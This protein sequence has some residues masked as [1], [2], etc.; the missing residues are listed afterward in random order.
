MALARG[1]PT[2][3]VM[4]KA[5][6]TINS[7]A[8][9]ISQSRAIAEAWA[10]S[11]V[12]WRGHSRA[13]PAWTLVPGVHRRNQGA[14][15]ERNI[16]GRFRLKAYTR[17][18]QCPPEGDLV[19]WLFLMQH[20]RLPT[21]LLDWSES[22]VVAA[23]FAVTENEAEDGALWALN[24]F[25]LNQ[26]QIGETGI[27]DAHAPAPEALLSLAFL[28]GKEEPTHTLAIYGREVDPRMLV[29]QSAFTIH[30]THTPIE[31]MPNADVFVNKYTIPAA[32]KPL[33]R[34]ELNS[35]GIQLHTLFPDL[36]HLA[37]YLADLHFA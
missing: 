2:L 1:S 20:Y 35:I 32:S 34:A 19:A 27:L 8:E 14:T 5:P 26:N 13:V 23:F 3:L 11:V 16:S 4:A 31:A 7:L 30:A 29:Q 12:W 28:P 18:H 9:L 15:Y 22:A 21:R 36:E 33:I 24:P 10:I 17:Y 37:E 25:A 6:G